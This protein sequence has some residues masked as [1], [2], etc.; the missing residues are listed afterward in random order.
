MPT[1]NHQFVL[2]LLVKKNQLKMYPIK[3]KI[4]RFCIENIFV[5]NWTSYR[6]GSS[7]IKAVTEENHKL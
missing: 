1:Q 2:K 3:F 7:Y 6:T 5:L 4:F